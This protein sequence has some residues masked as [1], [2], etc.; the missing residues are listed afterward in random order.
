MELF[1]E[2][3]PKVDSK[4][5]AEIVASPAQQGA[6]VPNSTFAMIQS[7]IQQGF[8]AEQLSKIMDLQDR[9]EKKS[10][11]EAFGAAMNAAQMEM[12]VVV[13]DKKGEKSRFATL[14]NV[15][16]QI[17]PIY[18]KHGFSL[19]FGAKNSAIEGHVGVYCDVRHIG[20]HCERYDNDFPLDRDGPKG[21]ANKTGIQAMGST[22]SY[23]R[24]YLTL[25]I[26]NITVADE[27]NDGNSSDRV[28]NQKEIGEINGRLDDLRE[29][30]QPVDFDKFLKWLGVEDLSKLTVLGFA[31]AITELKRKLAAV[32]A[33][34]EGAA[35]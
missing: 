8:N 35:Q 18:T 9:M 25:L 29:K 15:N 16:N 22:I 31:K 28:I 19:S 20:G 21:G 7:A 14:E 34:K 1:V 30:G 13:K 26:F 5:A 11:R 23:A 10:S 32:K 4:P 3:D 33:A 6:V 24:R 2:G 27:D 17:R 12:P